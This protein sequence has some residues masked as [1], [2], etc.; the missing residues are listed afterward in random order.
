MF[1]KTAAEY[2]QFPVRI[3]SYYWLVLAQISPKLIIGN[4]KKGL[5]IRKKKFFSKKK[6]TIIH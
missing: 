6:S 4:S 5:K 3:T 1:V 2:A